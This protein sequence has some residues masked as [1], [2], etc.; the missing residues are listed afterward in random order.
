MINK[1][2]LIKEV[3]SSEENAKIFL[4]QKGWDKY[5]QFK[6]LSHIVDEKLNK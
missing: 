5:Q 3:F 1:N 6:I 4:K 2:Q